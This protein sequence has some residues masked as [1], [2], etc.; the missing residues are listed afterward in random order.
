MWMDIF[1]HMTITYTNIQLFL[2]IYIIHTPHTTNRGRYLPTSF[3]ESNESEEAPTLGSQLTS[4]QPLDE[5]QSGLT[6][7]SLK[8]LKRQRDALSEDKARLQSE[9]I[10]SWDRKV[11]SFGWL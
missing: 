5:P 2:S 10:D 11:M 4:T 1:Q 9:L 8:H 6:P 3:Q 7:A